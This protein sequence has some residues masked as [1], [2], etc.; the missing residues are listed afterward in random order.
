MF[1]EGVPKWRP[2]GDRQAARLIESQSDRAISVISARELLQGARSRGEIKAI[3]Q[4]IR[5]AGIR[6]V[7]VSESISHVAPPLATGDPRHFRAIA[8]LEPKVF[9]PEAE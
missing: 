6:I 2:R 1:D 5:P 3:H 7:P 8:G 4:F 9:R